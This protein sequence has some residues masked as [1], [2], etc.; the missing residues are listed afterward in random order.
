[1]I[2]LIITTSM[3]EVCIKS[4]YYNRTRSGNTIQSRTLLS[5]TSGA[6]EKEIRGNNKG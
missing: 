4:C 5:P 3:H 1:M 6:F 2:V